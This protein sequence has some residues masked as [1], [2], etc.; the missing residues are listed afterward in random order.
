M[1]VRL[2]QQQEM[3]IYCETAEENDLNETE[4]ESERLRRAARRKRHTNY[5]M[6][7]HSERQNQAGREERDEG[8]GQLEE[9]LLRYRS[10]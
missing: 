10:H 5:R 9:M 8:G 7:M 1:T 2:Q 6:E 3:G 4:M